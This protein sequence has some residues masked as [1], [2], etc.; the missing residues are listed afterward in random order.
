MCWKVLEAAQ[1]QN[2]GVCASYSCKI[3]VFF[4]FLNDEKNDENEKET[5]AAK[6]K[7]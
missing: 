7:K 6:G 3:F 4:F 5:E 2:V 1:H